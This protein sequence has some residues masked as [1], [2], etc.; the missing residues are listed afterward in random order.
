MIILFF[1]NALTAIKLKGNSYR[2]A[3]SALG[4]DAHHTFCIGKQA[5]NQLVPQIM[6]MALTLSYF[7]AQATRATFIVL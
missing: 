1:L 3:H 5:P 4:L 2:Y 7:V 6:I